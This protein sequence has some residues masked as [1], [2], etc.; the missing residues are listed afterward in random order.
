MPRTL[1]V[2]LICCAVITAGT[3]HARWVRLEQQKSAYFAYI[4]ASC[5]N[6]KSF[7]VTDTVVLCEPT[8]IELLK[9]R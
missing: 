3:L 9:T 2:F 4:I 1:I 7:I 6:G 5:A 8:K